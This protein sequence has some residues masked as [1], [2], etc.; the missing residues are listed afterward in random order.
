MADE[1][2]LKAFES[3]GI[4]RTQTVVYLDLLKNKESSATEISKRTKMHRANVYD[5]LTKL[6]ERNLV[7][8]TN[9]AGGETGICC[10]FNRIDS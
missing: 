9:K 2:V 4:P 5:T 8:L 3:V 6:K 1:D 7:Y 10:S